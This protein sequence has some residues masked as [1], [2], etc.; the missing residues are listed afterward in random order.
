MLAILF[1]HMF[2]D[3]EYLLPN[4]EVA[5]DADVSEGD[6]RT[7]ETHDARSTGREQAIPGPSR[8]Q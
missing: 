5:I 6:L 7:P 4:P 8:L 2:E 1:P 3:L